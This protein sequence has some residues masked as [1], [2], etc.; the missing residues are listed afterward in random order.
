MSGVFRTYNSTGSVP[1]RNPSIGQTSYLKYS[2]YGI[3]PRAAFSG[4]VSGSSGTMY[5]SVFFGE[6][7]E[8]AGQRE[9]TFFRQ[10][11]PG[12]SPSVDKTFFT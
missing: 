6:R 12:A 11:T 2:V 9:C 1:Y 7:R 4:S 10:M 3:R 5:E 8:W